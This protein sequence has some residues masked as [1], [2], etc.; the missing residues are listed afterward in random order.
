MRKI[1]IEKFVFKLARILAAYLA[2]PG[3]ASHHCI[4]TTP[5]GGLVALCRPTKCR[6][7]GH[8]QD[9]RVG[10]PPRTAPRS[11][12]SISRSRCL[13]P[14]P[15]RPSWSW[16]LIWFWKYPWNYQGIPV[17]G[18]RW[19]LRNSCIDFAWPWRLCAFLPDF[20]CRMS[21]FQYFRI[22][23]RMSY[24]RFCNLR[25]VMYRDATRMLRKLKMMEFSRVWTQNVGMYRH[26]V[27][28]TW[29]MKT[30]FRKIVLRDTRRI[31]CFL[32]WDCRNSQI[33]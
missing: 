32:H 1:Q 22:R 26:S 2:W 14:W 3:K 29:M 6:S 23:N 30:V 27:N 28:N 15:H 5:F 9:L 7:G 18:K 10:A 25:V 20:G 31:R 24:F 33:R 21:E 8:V 17:L 11:L 19:C 12:H 13:T 16:C 4:Q